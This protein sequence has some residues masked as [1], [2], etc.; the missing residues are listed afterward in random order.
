M[1]TAVL[2]ALAVLIPL[3]LYFSLAAQTIR[4]PGTDAGGAVELV[5]MT[6]RR[7]MDIFPGT[8]NSPFPI[9]RLVEGT[10][11]RVVDDMRYRP[12]VTISSAC[13]ASVLAGCSVTSTWHAG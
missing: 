9:A 6:P 12:I 10:G 3:G 7:P 1:T 8:P 11:K 13:I 2:T 5:T 4:A